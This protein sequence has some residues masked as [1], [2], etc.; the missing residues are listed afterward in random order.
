MNE[1][2]IIIDIGNSFIKIKNNDKVSFVYSDELAVDKI[3][4]NIDLTNIDSVVISSVNTE[5]ECMLVDFFAANNITVVLADT[6]FRKQKFIDFSNIQGMGNDRKL[7]LLGALHFY[8]PPIITIDCG[9]AITINM[10][11]K[12][13]ICLG[14][15]IMC[16]IGTQTK[17]LSEYTSGLPT[18]KIN[19]TNYGITNNTENAINTGII[20]AVRGGIIDFLYNAFYREKLEN[21]NIIFAGGY[22]NLVFKLC[23]KKIHRMDTNS[24]KINKIE[25]KKDLVFFGLE[26]LVEIM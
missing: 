20:S 21:T 24:K 12:D 4:N 8:E 3:K 10:L 5:M 18:I 6:L 2:I 16:G 25:A 14:G 1:K 7:G 9:T 23:A 22:A 19:K 15:I 11:S 13:N 26:K 17:A